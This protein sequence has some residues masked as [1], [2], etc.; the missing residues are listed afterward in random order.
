[1]EKQMEEERAERGRLETRVRELE[2]ALEDPKVRP[3]IPLASPLA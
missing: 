2:S 1:M 3:E